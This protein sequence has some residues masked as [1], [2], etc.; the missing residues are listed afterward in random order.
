MPNKPPI[1]RLKQGTSRKAW[2]HGG[3]SR[4]ARGYGHAWDKLRLVVL[5]RDKHLCQPCRR[6]GRITPATAVDHIV[7][8]AKGGTDDLDNLEATCDPCH[9]AKT[10]HD[11][12]KRMRPRIAEDGWPEA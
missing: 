10:L 6:E 1:F 9:Q 7:P 3:R 2:D 5:A 4:Q 11:Q 12:G 8:K